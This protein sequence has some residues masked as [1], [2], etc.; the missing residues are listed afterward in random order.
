MNKRSI[1][2]AI[3]NRHR[4]PM[5]RKKVLSVRFV[6]IFTRAIHFP[7]ISSAPGVSTRLLILNRYEHLNIREH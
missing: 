4:R 6:V 1:I 2:R 3:L 5:H 7:M